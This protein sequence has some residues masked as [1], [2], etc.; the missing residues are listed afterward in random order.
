MPRLWKLGI[1]SPLTSN[2]GCPILYLPLAWF[3]FGELYDR[4]GSIFDPSMVFAYG[5]HSPL[6]NYEF[7]GWSHEDSRGGPFVTILSERIGHHWM[8]PDT[9]HVSSTRSLFFV[10]SQNLLRFRSMFWYTPFPTTP[11]FRGDVLCFKISRQRWSEEAEEPEST[12]QLG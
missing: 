1:S 6:A 5:R 8:R 10:E 4:F 7:Q 12:S 2:V 9:S 11:L 3:L